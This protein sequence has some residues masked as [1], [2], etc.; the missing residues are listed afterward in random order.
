VAMRE[1][2]RHPEPHLAKASLFSDMGNLA[3]S[4][5][6]VTEAERLASGRPEFAELLDDIRTFKRDLRE[7][8]ELEEMLEASGS[9]PPGLAGL[10]PDLLRLLGKTARRK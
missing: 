8:M 3:E 10:P 2:P 9:V 6:E 1:D 5:R 4:R 7:R